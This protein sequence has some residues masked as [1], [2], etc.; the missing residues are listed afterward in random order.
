MSVYLIGAKN[1][2]TRRQ[3]DAQQ[4]VDPTFVVAGFLDSDPAKH[5]TRFLD[6]PILGSPSMVGEIL[7]DDPDA[8]FVNL[9]TGST[10]ARW[11]VS[12]TVADGGGQFANLIHPGVNLADVTVGVGNYV[13][14]GV[15]IQAGARIGDNASI[16]IGAL[17][18]HESVVGDSAFVAHAVSISGE[19]HIGD[20]AFVGTNATIVPRV[21][22]G[23][24]A[25]VGAGA[26]VVKDVPDH[27][28]VVGNPARVIRVDDGPDHPA[29][30]FDR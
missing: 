9:I 21:R 8:R 15:I 3:I 11:E 19:V 14:D 4:A 10:R 6:L 13:Q 23:R 2:E 25:T 22:V 17:V 27:A 18:A 5:S 16:H 28:V 29:A 20:G 24:W 30:I 1:P 26:V 7:I 12:R